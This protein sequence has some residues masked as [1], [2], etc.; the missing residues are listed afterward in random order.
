MFRL[1]LAFQMLMLSL[2]GPTKCCCAFRAFQAVISNGGQINADEE[3]IPPKCCRQRSDSNSHENGNE[4][5]PRN[6]HLASSIPAESCHCKTCQCDAAMP[7][8]LHVVVRQSRLCP[9]DATFTGCSPL[10]K[11]AAEVISNVA[12]PRVV[13]PATTRSARS[14]CIDLHSWQC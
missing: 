4:V 3:S 7:L 11:T 10:T 2:T 6:I 5:P 9:D 1:L 8:S 12:I 13:P 14:I